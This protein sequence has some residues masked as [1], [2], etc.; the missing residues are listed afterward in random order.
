MKN[1]VKLALKISIL[2]LKTQCLYVFV[3]SGMLHYPF[4]GKPPKSRQP[5]LW[6]VDC[7]STNRPTN[8]LNN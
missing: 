3:F 6:S 5:F 8:Q 4:E 7:Q 2:K 1:E